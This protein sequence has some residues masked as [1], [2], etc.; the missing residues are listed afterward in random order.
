MPGKE[1]PP[2]LQIAPS[3]LAADFGRVADEIRAVEVGG[4]RMLQLDVMDGHFVPNITFGPPVVRSI[5]GATDLFLDVHLMIADP[6]AFLVPF[7]EA[8]ADLLTVHAEVL[9]DT[10]G[11]EISA[12][13]VTRLEQIAAVLS[14]R[15]IRLGLAFRPATD[16]LPWL[17]R[18]GAGLDLVLIMTVE[19]GFGG[20]AFMTDMLPRIG[21]VAD[22]RRQRGWRYRIEVD[23]G[24]DGAS[25]GP[26]AAAGA[27][28]LVAGSAVY[29]NRDRPAAI[30]A[31]LAAAT[32][33]ARGRA[34]A[35]G[36]PGP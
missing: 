8:G 26:C 34:P 19:P 23:G 25:A 21:A 24:V 31:L 30:G 6:M 12:A 18:V 2:G 22:L 9:A 3:L 36:L 17:E 16:P 11:P 10:G 15:G 14:P 29:G 27:E 32:A 7:A 4:A 35:S 5:R 33:A 13:A 1:I 20:Q 28:I